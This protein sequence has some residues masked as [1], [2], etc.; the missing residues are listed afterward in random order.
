[1]HVA[2][3]PARYMTRS[4]GLVRAFAD[5]PISRKLLAAFAGV[6]AVMA[7]SSAVVYSSLHVIEDAEIRRV[8]TAEVLD[9]LQKALD[10]M[11]DQETGLRGFLVSDDAV[12]LEPY[13]TGRDAFAAS[14]RQAEQLTLDNPAQQRRLQE[15]RALVASWNSEIAAPALALMTEPETRDEARA[16]TR[17]G[18]GKV[19]MDLVRAK[20]AEIAAV[21]RSLLATRDAAQEQA[22]ATAYTMTFLGAGA[23]VI[24]AILMAGVLARGIAIPITRM[25]RT[26]AAL[27]KGDTGIEARDVGRKD[28][29]GAMAKALEVFRSSIIERQK[30]QAELAHVHRVTTMGQLTASIAHEVN[31]PIGATL[32]NA[33]TALRWLRAHPPNLDEAQQALERIVGASKRAGAVIDRIRAIVNKAP[34]RK[35]RLDLNEAIEECVALTRSE[36]MKNGISLHT[37]FAPDLPLVEGDRIQLQQ[38]VLNLIFNAS[39]AMSI[40]DAQ[41]RDLTITTETDTSGGALVRIKDS[42]PGLAPEHID[43]LFDAFYTTKPG[44]MGMGLAICRSIVEGHGGRL[45]AA[46]NSPRGAVFQFEV[47]AAHS[48]TEAGVPVAS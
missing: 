9:T 31:Q 46:P 2:I 33:Q 11:L 15:L 13:R 35:S 44:G 16:A 3:V 23:S 37:A 14:L 38:V 22:F 19:A 8:H 36:V 10:A 41:Q 34:P 12:F 45:W 24:V 27:A 17:L 29:L 5:L 1:M 40:G 26:M 32:I 30:A 25:T 48:T 4:G 20:V 42:G 43:H 6:I 21:E 47:P 39:E 28:E 18:A 7:V